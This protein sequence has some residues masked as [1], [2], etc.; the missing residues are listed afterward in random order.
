MSDY[1]DEE[2]E[3]LKRKQME[4][5]MRRKQEEERRR[6]EELAREAQ[7][8]EIL[9]KVMTPEAR[10]RLTNVKLVRPEL[11]TAVEEYIINLALTGQL[12]GVVD[13]ATLKQI[14]YAIDSRTRRE[15]RI[16][17]REKR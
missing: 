12:R 10:A 11:A 7:K 14:L 4:E 1:Y 2:L 9:R 5:I 17:I 6:K 3:E 15:F 16:N 13:D 8:Q